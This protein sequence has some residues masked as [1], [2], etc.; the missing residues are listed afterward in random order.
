MSSNVAQSD[1]KVG[2]LEE[3]TASVQAIPGLMAVENAE[4]TC[5][6]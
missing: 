6:R 5:I 1:G 3:S 2:Y 4:L